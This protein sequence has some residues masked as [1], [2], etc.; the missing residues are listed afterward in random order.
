VAA[1]YLISVNREF[2]VLVNAGNL[3]GVGKRVDGTRLNG[4]CVQ[5][6]RG[7]DEVDSGS[8]RF[9]GV[10]I[11]ILERVMRTAVVAVRRLGCVAQI[12]AIQRYQHKRGGI[13]ANAY[14]DLGCVAGWRGGFIGGKCR[15]SMR[16]RVGQSG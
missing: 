6:A 5:R 2:I 4:V 8:G 9:A 14:T 10:S 7:T 15:R 12:R 1:S 11:N 13:V 16:L 3:L